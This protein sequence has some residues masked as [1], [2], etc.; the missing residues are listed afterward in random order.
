MG[1][2]NAFCASRIGIGIDA[3]NDPDR[4]AP[5]ST[6][7]VRVEQTQIGRDVSLVVGVH[8]L[9]QRWSFF[10]ERLVQGSLLIEKHSDDHRHIMSTSE[11]DAV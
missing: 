7:C 3:E 9:S 5:V 10:P 4:L 8:P 2:V 11:S 1:F 6:F